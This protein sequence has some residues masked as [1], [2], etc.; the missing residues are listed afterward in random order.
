MYVGDKWV[1]SSLIKD[2]NNNIKNID[3][4]ST[5]KAT[6]V[7]RNNNPLLPEKDLVPSHSLADWPNGKVVAEWT[8]TETGTIDSSKV[9]RIWLALRIDGVTIEG[10]E[11]IKVYKGIFS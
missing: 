6:V 7:D 9:D 5:I 10:T 8:E 11:A 1:I 3:V 2:S 4:G